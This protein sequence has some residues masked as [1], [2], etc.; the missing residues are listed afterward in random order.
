MTTDCPRCRKPLQIVKLGG[1]NVDL[2]RVCEGIW[3]DK[4]E[5]ARVFEGTQGDLKGTDA[6]AS[7]QGQK[8]GGE[9]AGRHELSCPR[10]TA[11]LARYRYG[12]TT[13][14]LID[15]CEQGC[16][17]WVDDGEIRRIF[18]HIAESQRPLT[19]EERARLDT[20]LMAAEGEQARKEKMFVENLTKLDERPGP[21]G[22]VGKII[23]FLYGTFY[24]AGRR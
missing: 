22:A 23:Q 10:C 6:A 24:K 9:E 1:V 20:V 19:A 2:C 4:E 7:W 14:I 18:E 13:E 12:A 3:F 5:L 21:V 16:G 17:V 11:R 15:G 8:R